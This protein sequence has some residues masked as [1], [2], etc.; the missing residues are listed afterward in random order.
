VWYWKKDGRLMISGG[1][2]VAEELLTF[3]GKPFVMVEG[4]PL[5]VT[6]DAAKEHVWK[7]AEENPSFL[8]RLLCEWPQPAP[9]KRPS[10]SRTDDDRVASAEDDFFLALKK[11]HLTQLMRKESETADEVG[12]APEVPAADGPSE[13]A[14]SAA[15]EDFF[16][17]LKRMRD[18]KTAKQCPA[19]A[20]PAT[21]MPDG[22]AADEQSA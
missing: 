2:P 13:Q 22:G 18:E 1:D 5:S 10:G 3:A 7:Q 8:E 15:V 6:L 4:V 11:L 12:R 9:E 14:P 19:A 16:S 20:D 17:K 21:D